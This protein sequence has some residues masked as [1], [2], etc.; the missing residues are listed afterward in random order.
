M[1]QSSGNT[2]Q[3]DIYPKQVTYCVVREGREFRVDCDVTKPITPPSA[4]W[5]DED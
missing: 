4:P 3:M 1:P 2:W 5:G